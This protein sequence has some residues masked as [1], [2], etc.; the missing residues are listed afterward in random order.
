MAKLTAEQARERFGL[1][2]NESHA[3]GGSLEDGAL[4]V[5]GNYIGSM[6]GT[7]MEEQRS[8]PDKEAEGIGKYKAIEDYAIENGFG[9]ERAEWNS[10]NDVQG[11]IEQVVGGDGPAEEAPGAEDTFTPESDQIK[12]AKERVRNYENDILSGETSKRIYGK[13]QGFLDKYQFNAASAPAG[14]SDAAPLTAKY[15]EDTFT[16]SDI[17]PHDTTEPDVQAAA[18]FLK[19]Q[20]NKA[21]KQYN[22][23]PVN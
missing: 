18:S 16:G 4:F 11:A 3:S 17:S 20:K 2:Y 8:G 6:S 23:K 21:I 13:N 15:E 7:Q 14:A 9:E 12:Q 10:Y 1:N 19:S 5:N 22:I